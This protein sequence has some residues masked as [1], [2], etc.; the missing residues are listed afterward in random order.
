MKKALF[1]KIQKGI[2]TD[3]ISSNKRPR[4]L[5]DSEAVKRGAN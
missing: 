2:N 1:N 3:R 4:R 5:L